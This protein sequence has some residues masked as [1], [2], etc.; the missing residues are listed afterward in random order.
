M[1]TELEIAKLALQHIGDRFDIASLSEAS[2]EAE[3]VNLVFDHV[4]DM[5]LR[6]HP[7]SFARKF[8]SPVEITGTAPDSWDYMYTY[9]TDGLKVVR[10]VN[11]LGR[12]DPPIKF[13]VALNSS[14]VKVI[15]CDL[16]EAE[17]EYIKA[18]T[19][20]AVFDPA[21]VLALSYRLAQ[22]IAIPLTGDRG[23][24]AE[25]KNMAD[26]M[27]SLAKGEDANQGLEDERMLTPDW[28]SVRG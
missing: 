5:M 26:E 11:P 8:Q 7:W 9:P 3:Q 20:P 25:M 22:Y 6:V 16:G 1:A 15:L 2:A 28:I 21:F 18:I 27:T 12:V 24:A 10:V 19:D 4:R 13:T 14:N 23:I 17:I